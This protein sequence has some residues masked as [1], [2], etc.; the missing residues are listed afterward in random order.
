MHY[1]ITEQYAR[2]EE[3][4]IAEFCELDDAQIFVTKKISNDEMQH[5]KI[6]YRL[7]D[8]SQLLKKFNPENISIG[9]ARYAEEDL[10]ITNTI[11]FLFNVMIQTG[12]SLERK[13]IA[14]FNDG[15]D[16]NLFIIGKCDTD[17]TVHDNDLFC[18]FKGKI[19]MK[20]LNK[21]IIANQKITSEGSS[22][23]QSG[24][25]FRPTPIPTRP[26]PPGGPSDCWVE[27]DDDD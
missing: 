19:L 20:N 14:N 16:A 5:K 6:I 3:K 13:N 7:Y 4:P 10:D 22:A 15:N 8:D 18:I 21:M 17:S 12:D 1:K 24:A 23:N 27:K 26:T 2:G 9:Y 11:H 25:T